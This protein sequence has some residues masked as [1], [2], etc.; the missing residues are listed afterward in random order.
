MTWQ[1]VVHS[2]LFILVV[3]MMIDLFVV[4]VVRTR[5][6]ED[7]HVQSWE[8]WHDDALRLFKVQD[9]G[10]TLYIVRG[11]VGVGGKDAAPAMVAGPGSR[12]VE[13]QVAALYLIC[14]K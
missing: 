1:K 6:A 3:V 13:K 7:V 9:G 2:I 10:C 11:Y 12:C 8:I 4:G 5:A 14:M